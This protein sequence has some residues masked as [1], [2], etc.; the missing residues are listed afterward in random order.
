MALSSPVGPAR[1]I[2]LDVHRQSIT[3]AG[4][5]QEQPLVLCP[6]RM[7]RERICRLG[8]RPFGSDR[9]CGA[10]SSEPCLD[11]SQTSC[12]LGSP[13]S[14]WPIGPKWRA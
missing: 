8:A 9:C 2:G 7:A 5:D 1:F 14:L 10:R 11:A 6:R 13:P 4:V 3:A 12:S